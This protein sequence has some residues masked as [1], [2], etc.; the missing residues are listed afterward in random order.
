MAITFTN[1]P[2]EPV[3]AKKKDVKGKP[4]AGRLSEVLAGIRKDKGEK[5]VVTGDTIPIVRRL[6]TGIF[7]FD[8][9]TG[10]GFPCGRYSI[11]YGPESSN[12]TNVALKAVVTAQHLPPPC[13]KAVWVN[14]EQSF[15]PIWAER[16]GVNTKE[17]LVVQAGYGEEAID[18]VDALVRAEDVALL[19]VD[20][21]AGLIASKEIAQS[22]ENY[23]IGSSALLIK[24][25]VNKLMIAFCEEQKRD[26]DPCI[27]LINQTRFKP[28]VMFG[29]PETMPGGEAQKFLASLR[30]R[31]SAKNIIEKATNTLV[32]KET[33]VVVK[34]AKVPVRTTSFDF[35]MCVNTHDDF[36]VGDTDSF[37]MV[38]SHL[39]ALNLLVKTTKGYAIQ[40]GDPVHPEWAFPTLTAMQDHYLKDYGFRMVIQG[41]V[42]EMYKAKLVLVEESDYSP[43]DVPPG[44]AVEVD[45]ETGEVHEDIKSGRTELCVSEW[46]ST[47]PRPER[48]W[49]LSPLP[50]APQRGEVSVQSCRGKGLSNPVSRIGSPPQARMP[51]AR[52]PRSGW[53]R[54]WAHVSTPTPGLCEA[55]SPTRVSPRSAWR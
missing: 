54:Q 15:D 24:R 45:M 16:M 7:E 19:V 8:F 25:M 38:K 4:I 49:S 53:P 44:T 51:M 48:H 26:H 43:K 33:H 47:G 2:P 20:S 31:L 40:T 21:M 32:F 28:G 30:V 22:V 12:K 23:D 37:T 39:Q 27:I 13:N 14:V 3:P 52:S 5:V 9:Y 1:Q 10:G 6:P 50:P 46:Y 41:L 18:L 36:A 17:L 34:K 29:D 35:K 55:R 11:V 42:I